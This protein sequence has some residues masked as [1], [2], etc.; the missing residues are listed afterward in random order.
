MNKTYAEKTAGYV[1]ASIMDAYVKA[2]GMTW[3]KYVETHDDEQAQ[4]L[5]RVASVEIIPEP[6]R[7][8]GYETAS[9]EDYET[10]SSVVAAIAAD[11]DD[12]HEPAPTYER[13]EL[14]A[15]LGEPQDYDVDAIE[16]EATAYDPETGRT[17]W[18]VDSDQ[19]AAICERY[20]I[21]EYYPATA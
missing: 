3:S 5:Y 1:V 12:D 13:H 18:T 2:T 15:Y 19:L 17:V 11:P 14:E 8:A 10:V 21:V 4:A 16:A 6:E 9:P 20:Q 7:P